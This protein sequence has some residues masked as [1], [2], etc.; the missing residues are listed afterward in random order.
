[1]TLRCA[2]L[3]SVSQ[4][5]AACFVWKLAFSWS[6]YTH[7]CTSA[8]LVLLSLLHQLWEV[9][10]S[11]KFKGSAINPWTARAR[12]MLPSCKR[13]K[14]TFE[15][16]QLL[17]LM[18]I[19][20][21]SDSCVVCVYFWSHLHLFLHVSRSECSGFRHKTC[22]HWQPRDYLCI[23]GSFKYQ[24]RYSAVFTMQ[25]TPLFTFLA[26]SFLDP[27]LKITASVS[28]AKK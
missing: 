10:L 20:V 26:C 11:Q 18:S 16:S 6:S 14:P 4:S 28:G 17:V 13:H 8:F 24:R 9:G 21:S 19:Y 1:M 25:L 7:M 2:C 27:D 12:Q 5:A 15:P 3:K 23:A 22:N